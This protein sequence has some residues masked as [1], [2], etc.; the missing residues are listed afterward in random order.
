MQGS[1]VVYRIHIMRPKE[2]GV[3]TEQC[4]QVVPRFCHT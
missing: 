4:T 2:D 3:E 1:G